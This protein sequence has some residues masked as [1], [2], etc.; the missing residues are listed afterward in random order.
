MLPAAP[1]PCVSSQMT[2]CDVAHRGVLAV[3]PVAALPDAVAISVA[4]TLASVITAIEIARGR[5]HRL[6]GGGGAGGGG[7]F[8]CDPFWWAGTG[9]ARLSPRHR[10]C[11]GA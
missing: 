9:G 7:V 8:M 11:P 6:A 10:M 2:S 1:L 4:L 3:L 5:E